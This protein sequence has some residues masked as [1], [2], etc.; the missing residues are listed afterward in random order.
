MTTDEPAE[1][2][3]PFRGPSPR[4]VGGGLLVAAVVA[5]VVQN[6]EDTDI[7]WL[8]LEATQPLWVVLLVTAAATLLGAELITSAYRRRRRKKD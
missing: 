7:N 4:L 2:T 8:F 6:T 3:S 1:R 5:F